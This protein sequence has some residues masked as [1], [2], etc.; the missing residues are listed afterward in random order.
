MATTAKIAGSNPRD[1]VMDSGFL[2]IVET[3]FEH[4]KRWACRQETKAQVSSLDSLIHVLLA[5]YRKARKHNRS[6]HGK[7]GKARLLWDTLVNREFLACGLPHGQI[8]CTE[9]RSHGSIRLA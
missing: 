8:Y 7:D 2:L 4:W 6:R 9:H 1:P 5:E 3:S